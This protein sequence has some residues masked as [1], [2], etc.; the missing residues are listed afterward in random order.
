M[1]SKVIA[2]VFSLFSVSFFILFYLSSN[3]RSEFDNQT[4]KYLH[5]TT[6]EHF[7][8]C[9]SHFS[10]N[11]YC[12]AIHYVRIILQQ[13][14]FIFDIWFYLYESSASVGTKVSTSRG[15][16]HLCRSWNWVKQSLWK[17]ANAQLFCTFFSF[18]A[19]E[20]N[21]SS[22]TLLGLSKKTFI[23]TFKIKIPRMKILLSKIALNCRHD[24]D[25]DDEKFI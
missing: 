8:K 21:L 15:M 18:A 12:N 20:W 25:D 23:E 13:I 19:D 3:T 17:N 22:F 14:D 6:I 16:S 4:V 24:D 7:R 11:I 10:F 5:T 2:V 1:G 9:Q